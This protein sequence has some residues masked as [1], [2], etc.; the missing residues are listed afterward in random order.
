MDEKENRSP[1]TCGIISNGLTY[2]QIQ[3]QK[4]KKGM[5]QKKYFKRL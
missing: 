5:G 4:V 1:K 2:L 3:S